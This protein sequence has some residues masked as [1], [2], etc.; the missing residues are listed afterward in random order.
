MQELIYYYPTLRKKRGVKT[1]P[2]R[3]R[4]CPQNRPL[5]GTILTPLFR[6]GAVFHKKK[7]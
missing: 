3:H 4:F 5:C 2:Q 6:S 7:G 1:A